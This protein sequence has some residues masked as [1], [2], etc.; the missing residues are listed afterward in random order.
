MATF[1]IP[2]ALIWALIGGIVWPL[3]SVWVV[4]LAIG[5]AYAF[6]YGASE[7]L[8]LRLQGPSF[9]W[10]VPLDWVR[11][12]RMN[13]MLMWGVTLGPGLATR[14]PFASLWI[15]IPLLALMPSEGSSL[16]IGALVGLVHGLAR[17]SSVLALASEVGPGTAGNVDVTRRHL[18]KLRLRQYDGLLL[19]VLGGIL[20]IRL[21]RSAG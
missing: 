19:L 1:A 12:P 10:Q 18:D 20:L 4:I 5:V 9:D 2:A 11:A 15:L 14:N 8:G 17:A 7:S 16:T 3:H 13:L 21:V 6:L